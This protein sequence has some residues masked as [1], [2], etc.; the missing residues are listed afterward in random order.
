MTI[1]KRETL[2]KWGKQKQKKKVAVVSDKNE[3]SGNGKEIH[4]GGKDNKA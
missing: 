3:V 4:F 2:K 1:S